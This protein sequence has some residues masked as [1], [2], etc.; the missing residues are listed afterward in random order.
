MTIAEQ[1]MEIHKWAEQ[2]GVLDEVKH[3]DALEK[4]YR[5]KLVKFITNVIEELPPLLENLMTIMDDQNQTSSQML[6]K[7]QALGNA[8]PQVYNVLNFALRQFM[9]QPYPTGSRHAQQ[10]QPQRSP[11]PQPQPH[12]SPAPQPQPHRSPAPQP[13][14][15]RSPASQPQQQRNPKH[16]RVRQD[17]YA[18]RGFDRMEER[19]DYEPY[20]YWK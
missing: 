3:Y 5:K 18:Y 12:R 6:A 17:Q 11:A 13:Q 7:L 4:K 15:Q 10:H 2:N 8:S 1:K 16:G 20:G 14:P 19:Y 9:V